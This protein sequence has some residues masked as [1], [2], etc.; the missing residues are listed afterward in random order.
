MA[1]V[2]IDV[3][4]LNRPFD[5]QT[6]D[7]IRLESEAVLLILARVER[8]ELA[9][10]SSDVIAAE[11]RKT[12]DPD[13][14]DRL[15]ALVKAAERVVEFNEVIEA[16]AAEIAPLGFKAFDDLHLASAEAAGADLLL[17]TDDRLLRAAGRSAEHLRVQVVNPLDWLREADGT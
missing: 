6:Q 13:R 1:I 2:Y 9:W 17:T 10:I 15:V 3:C 7:R 11:I 8:G 4:C 12:P 16:R 14:R 5:D